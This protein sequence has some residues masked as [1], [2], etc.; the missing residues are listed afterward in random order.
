MASESRG[1]MASRSIGA[2]P[3]A[4]SSASLT[5]TSGC[6][7]R[8][9]SPTNP[10]SLV[11]AMS[12]I[13]NTGS[14]SLF[15][16]A[17]TPADLL[18]V[19]SRVEALMLPMCRFGAVRHGAIDTMARSHDAE[20]HMTSE[21]NRR[22]VLASR[23][24]GMPTDENFRI[25]EAPVPERGDGEA[26]V[27]TIWLSVDPY[28]RGAMRGPRTNVGE[29]ITA[30]VVGE[31]M[32]SESP[33][34]AAGQIV[35]GRL[36]W[37]ACGTLATSKLR[38]VDAAIA[39][40]RTATG[41]LGMPGLTAY[42][43][44]LEVGQP[45]PGDTVVVS[46]AAGA[47]GSAVG[48]IAHIKGARAVGIAGNDAKCR[49]LTD[50]LGFDAAINYRT[51]DLSTALKRACP[52]GIDVYFDNVGGRI[53]DTVLQHLREHA[54]IAI[55]GSISQYN[56]EEPELAPR[57]S[58]ALA[59]KHARMEGL[60][61][62]DYADRHEHGLRELAGWIDAGKLKYREDIVEGLEN[63]PEAFFRLFSGANIGK[64]LVKVADEPDITAA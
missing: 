60:T 4:A 14:V 16:E 39:P 13:P 2:E 17:C 61:V 38:V 18:T 48:Q 25:E 49:H 64:V 50:D 27:R 22:I 63:A 46:A 24:Q 6:A 15:S 51:D 3:R 7:P 53:L 33:D 35:V 52:D 23:P 9:M 36:G 12:H 40:I 41:I 10:R 5:D 26:I 30:E 54:R 59:A 31:V 37:Q 28:M 29:V 47:V 20:T 58:T 11:V 45:H 57:H 55:C 44:L 62:H 32:A 34:V 42:F 8:L 21:M 1:V 19:G 56:L 43:G